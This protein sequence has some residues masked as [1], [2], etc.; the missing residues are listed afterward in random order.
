MVRLHHFFSALMIVVIIVGSGAS[1]NA[2]VVYAAEQPQFAAAFIDSRSMDVLQSL[3]PCDVG[4]GE[5]VPAQVTEAFKRVYEQYGG[6]D[7]LGAPELMGETYCTYSW[8][9]GEQIR[10]KQDFPDQPNR[11]RSSIIWSNATQTA[12]VLFGEILKVYADRKPGDLYP[13]ASWLGDPI[14]EVSKAPAHL[15]ARDGRYGG[16]AIAYFER[17]FISRYQQATAFNPYA[18]HPAICD[19]QVS[20]TKE[21]ETLLQINVSAKVIRA[22]GWP[23]ADNQ[24]DP[25]DA[26]L[27]IVRADGSKH[28][29]GLTQNSSVDFSGVVKAYQ[30][31]GP[32]LEFDEDIHFY[33]DAYNRK[34]E[35]IRTFP[36]DVVYQPGWAMWDTWSGSTDNLF[37]LKLTPGSTISLNNDNPQ[38]GGVVGG[39]GFA[40]LPPIAVAKAKSEGTTA[41][42][43]FI[44]DMGSA[45]Q[46][47]YVLDGSQSSDPDGG[48]LSYSW[49]LVQCPP[50]VL[51]CSGSYSQAVNPVVR[52]S[53]PDDIGAW[54]YRLTV[55]DDEGESASNIVTVT[56]R[57]SDYDNDGLSDLYET[58]DDADDSLWYETDLRNGC[59]PA[60]RKTCFND[61]DTDNDWLADGMEANPTIITES[62][63]FNP[64]YY[65]PSE[66]YRTVNFSGPNEWYART[67]S[68]VPSISQETGVYDYGNSDRFFKLA[69]QYTSKGPKV[70]GMGLRCDFMVCAP[71]PADPKDWFDTIDTDVTLWTN[72]IRYKGD[73]YGGN[74]EA[75]DAV[76]HL[77][78]IPKVRSMQGDA[79]TQIEQVK[80]HLIERMNMDNGIQDLQ[81]NA[82]VAVNFTN[83]TGIKD[84]KDVPGSLT[85][86]EGLNIQNKRVVSYQAARISAFGA[87]V[88]TPYGSSLSFTASDDGGASVDLG[89]L[90]FTYSPKSESASGIDGRYTDNGTYSLNQ[91]NLLEIS[92]IK[93]KV[94][95][96]S[97]EMIFAWNLSSDDSDNDA[98]VIRISMSGTLEYSSHQDPGHSQRRVVQTDEFQTSMYVLLFRTDSGQVHAVPL[99]S[100]STILPSSDEA[101]LKQAAPASSDAVVSQFD[102]V[103]SHAY[104][105]GPVAEQAIDDDKD[106]KI[107]VLQLSV[108]VFFPSV[109]RFVAHGALHNTSGVYVASSSSIIDV[110]T[111]GQY[112]V[113]LLYNGPVLRNTQ[114][115]GPYIMQNF[116]LVKAG[117][118]EV[119]FQGTNLHS[120]SEYSYTQF[121]PSPVILL[122]NQIKDYGVDTDGNGKY[123]FL[124][125][126]TAFNIEK[127][128]K[129]VLRGV[130]ASPRGD[131]I[132][133]ADTI[134]QL[135][136][137][138]VQIPLLF[139]GVTIGKSHINGPYKV[140]ALEL[141]DPVT[142]AVIGS[143][144]PSYTTQPYKSSD[145]EGGI[146]APDLARAENGNLLLHMGP[147][148]D[149]RGVAEDEINEQFT[150]RQLNAEGTHFSI[151]A[152]GM[153]EEEII[154]Q[155]GR[156]LANGGDGNDA[157][158][159]KPGSGDGGAAVYFSTDAEIEGGLGNDQIRT[160]AGN[161]LIK[162]GAGD[163][164]LR[165]HNGNDTLLGGAGSDLIIGGAGGDVVDGERDGDII[166]GDWSE[167]GSY[168][169]D[170][171]PEL[172][173][174]LLGGHGSDQIY[175]NAGDDQLFGDEQLACQDLGASSGSDTLHGGAGNDQLLGGAGSDTINGDAGDDSLCG[176][177][178][179]DLLDGDQAA[180]GAA[181]GNDNLHGG[182]G[183]DELH[184]RDGDDCLFG[185]AGNDK[186]FGEAGNDNLSGG[187]GADELDGGEERDYLFG[188][189]G[190]VDRPA[191]ISDAV[192]VV[193]SEDIGDADHAQGGPGDDVLYGEGGDD[194]LHGGAGQDLIV[195]NTG[196]DSLDGEDG[197][198]TLSGN[199]GNDTVYGSAGDDLL[200][201]HSGRD[202][203]F[204]GAGNDRGFGGPDEDLLR[205]E[206]GDDYLEG[207]GGADD[208]GGGADNDDLIG[209]SMVTAQSDAGDHISG[210]A[211][212]DV[213]VGDNAQINRSGDINAFDGSPRRTVLL[214]DI[215]VDDAL[216]SGPDT[217]DGGAGNDRAY[218]QGADDLISGADGDDYLEGNA[219]ADTVYGGSGQDDIVGGSDTAGRQDAADVLWGD[220]GVGD[221]A[222]DHDVITGDNA[223]VIRPLNSG[224]QWQIN[225]FNMSILRSVIL[226]DVGAVGKP[227][228]PAGVS[229]AE[230]IHG[231]G[232]DDRIYGQG[233][234]DSIWGGSGD[235]YLEGNA[236]SDMI[237]GEN[238]NDDILGGTG[239]INTD[240][241]QGADGR[242]DGGDIL[243]GGLGFDVIAGDNAVLART[244]VA[245]RWQR[246]SFNAGIEHAPRIL[247]DV[248]ALQATLVSGPDRIYGDG[249]DDLFYGQGGNDTLYGGGGDDYGEGNAADDRLY[250]EAGQDDLIG[251][252]SQLGL[253]DGADLIDG[254]A[255]A[256][257]AAGDNATIQRPVDGKGRWQRLAGY[258]YDIVVRTVT[259]SSSSE[260]SS[261]YGNDQI[262]GGDGPDELYGQRGAD[263]I[264]G[265]ESDDVI[266][267]DL[268]R[269]T[270]RIED[271]SR[272]QVIRSNQPFLEETLYRAGTLTRQVELFASS[273]V[274]GG[275]DII[276]GGNGADSLHGGPGADLLNGNAGR[277]S[278]FGD[279]GNDAAW[280]GPDGDYLWGGY[281]D[282]WLDV[283]PRAASNGR[284]ADPDNWFDLAGVDNYQGYDYV[285]GGWG[286]DGMQGDVG[287]PGPQPGDRLIDWV[288][289]Y[290]AYYVCPGAYGQGMITRSHSPS[291]IQF[292]Q[293]LAE[294]GGAQDVAMS[295]SS[296][297]REIGIVFSKE[298]RFNANPPHPDHPAHFTC[299]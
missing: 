7:V 211:G 186:L 74:G 168:T 114:Q 204:G 189:N 299:N 39:E 234:N 136:A 18:Y 44:A 5:G 12:Y 259:M 227:L 11:G 78:V 158:L 76:F 122:K 47:A 208:I 256:D 282:D 213:I 54:V 6:V 79:E 117:T 84:F 140:V 127:A 65:V 45:R 177:D 25:L 95:I 23:T 244:L 2:H 85:F 142:H 260:I 289:A 263:R 292:L 94:D 126:T 248:D 169:G 166:W 150:V 242:L 188:D 270:T 290:N 109:G 274:N 68:S 86:S 201:G 69:M 233:S 119:I 17:G 180:D 31:T 123:N 81:V 164:V 265:D 139:D 88:G 174:T 58:Q 179:D 34:W 298:S 293:M 111:P 141:A 131:I 243:H 40:L 22:P 145:F 101:V 278:V 262:T 99:Q 193:F 238:G 63:E 155:G 80:Q 67:T 197:D 27:T 77:S 257:V 195:G 221:S 135:P 56:V 160:G 240:S 178:G 205:G 181:I 183:N 120:T 105:D 230:E 219:G 241:A 217:I 156:V 96:N 235:D 92:A 48:S 9:D 159:L 275:S 237:D 129:Y 288:G 106:G 182:D 53:Q 102:A 228:V 46:Y 297:F 291:V 30:W 97:P 35:N 90:K 148:S 15:A 276:L 229:G 157:I 287:G 128:G 51:L 231:Q 254:G 103:T 108:P 171:A 62:S 246:N 83:V 266:L 121:E 272:Q 61:P 251:G 33:L 134:E 112:N 161:D 14:G 267:G 222:T 8:F 70:R 91:P 28:W 55:T 284:S 286:Q 3:P 261:S 225:A 194:T 281:G 163:D 125:I 133:L 147:E 59:F 223:Q 226:Y 212:H 98:D 138:D 71:N 295:Q 82:K 250:G 269:V 152:F 167:M 202:S 273:D 285:Y 239:R 185:E 220:D 36:K 198:D 89:Y 187:L 73:W 137:G 115:D 20:I 64:Y 130:L 271:G 224:G 294:S 192:D 296:G 280:G 41:L 118:Q 144:S 218:G 132:R 175:G 236:G 173:D 19:V 196:D 283:K 116:S 4:Q 268:G 1:N 37:K 13:S 255:D 66:L 191:G 232:G 26:Y 153:Y 206:G 93:E 49:E 107:N 203:L 100:P 154:D 277:D 124:H 165:G 113:P 149:M 57:D 252:S 29:M 216:L 210:D 24:S 110:E 258:G 279:D 10:W 146:V 199:A 42:N 214:F 209:G 104:I 72:N 50:K 264:Q 21:Y 170:T 172:N 207:N 143:F 38:C 215:D 162:G 200:E 151:E 43:P 32:I 60:G 247:R 87:G 52:S 176:N 249:D 75:G 184:G 253:S 16:E 245:G 190:Y